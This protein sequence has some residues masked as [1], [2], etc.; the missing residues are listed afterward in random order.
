MLARDGMPAVVPLCTADASAAPRL[1][2]LCAHVRFCSL[3]RGRQSSAQVEGLRS[4]PPSTRDWAARVT[5]R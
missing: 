1:L 3:E 4:G 5:A 2:L